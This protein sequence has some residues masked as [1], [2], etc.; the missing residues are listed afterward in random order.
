MPARTQRKSLLKTVLSELPYLNAALWLLQNGGRRHPFGKKFSLARLEQNLPNWVAQAQHHRAAQAAAAGPEGLPGKRILIFATLRY[1][2]EH[3]TLLSIALAGQGHQV[4]LSYQPFASWRRPTNRLLQRQMQVYAQKVLQKASPL[5]NVQPLF[6]RTFEL[7]V[8]TQK[9]PAGAAS[10]DLPLLPED[11]QQA[12]QELNIRDVQYTLQVEEVDQHSKLFRL[13]QYRNLQ[14]TLNAIHLME[15]L[16]PEVVITPN[17]SILE[18]GAVYLA[19]RHLNLPV[20]TYEFGEQRGRIWLAQ[21]S[22]V[23]RQDTDELWQAYHSQPLTEAEWDKIRALMVSRQ[24]ASLWENFSRQWQGLPMQGGETVRQ[25]LNL[26]GRP[27]VL[28]PANVIGDSLT[29][30]RQVFTASM[31]EWLRGTVRYFASRPDVQLVVRIHPGERYIKGPSVADVVKA[32]LP[33]L[34]TDP[35]LAHIRLVAALDPVNTYDL[36]E[37]ADLGLVYTTTVGLE[38]ALSGV[39]V[40]VAGQTHYRGKGFTLDPATWQEAEQM[41][42]TVLAQPAAAR[43]SR[44][45]LE[46]AWNYAYRFFFCYPLAFPWHLLHYWKDLEEWPVDK[47][48][49]E[50]GQNQFGEAFRCLAGYPRSWQNEANAAGYA[51]VIER[52]S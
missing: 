47:V 10:G 40:V 14:A 21:N 22:E 20:V 49:A 28:L 37:I 46:Q 34:D 45:Q 50:E 29:L 23:M 5:V 16:Q 30:G 51:P 4:T 12:L 52:G 6:E 27:V 31:T 39:P 48:L 1:W 26:D 15:T 13:R 42:E 33:D 24:R 35:A 41:I 38:M 17:G 3:A 11:M 44:A 7:S 25:A 19:A 18:M 2:I 43:L 32:E 9:A 8:L 36:V